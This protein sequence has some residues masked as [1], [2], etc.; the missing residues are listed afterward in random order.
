MAQILSFLV[1]LIADCDTGSAMLQ[2][3]ERVYRD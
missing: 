2:S 3:K 1:F